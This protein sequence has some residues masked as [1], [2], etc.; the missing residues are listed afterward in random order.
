MGRQGI[1]IY[2]RSL[3]YRNKVIRLPDTWASCGRG[4][5][6]TFLVGIEKGIDVRLAL[7]VIRK[8][9]RNDYDVALIFS[10]DQDL[11]EVADEI[12]DVAQGQGGWI[13]I[14]SA[15]PSSPV[16]RNRR[17]VGKTDWLPIDRATYDNCIDSRD[18]RPKRKVWRWSRST[19][20]F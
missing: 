8:A 6:Y 11:S 17:G 4:K 1:K 7:D 13:K 9:L 5:R 12:R 19:L 16:Y 10:Q 20:V 3:V 18:Y 14:A 15:Y 2:S